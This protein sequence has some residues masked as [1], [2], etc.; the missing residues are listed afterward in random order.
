MEELWKKGVIVDAYFDN[1]TKIY[2]FGYFPNISCFL[3]AKSGEEAKTILNKLALVEKEMA[4]YT[5]Y[6]EGTIENVYFDVEGTQKTNE[7][8]D[9]VFFVNN[10]WL[11]YSDIIF[12]YNNVARKT[13]NFTLNQILKLFRIL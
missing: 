11:Y 7:V 13:V 10:N 6:P 4:E 8:I 2:K 3:K 5:I 1:D 9:F 12:C